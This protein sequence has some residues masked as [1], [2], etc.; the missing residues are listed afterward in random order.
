MKLS[1]FTFLRNADVDS[2]STCVV[3]SN[4]TNITIPHT[5]YEHKAVEFCP[6]KFSSFNAFFCKKKKKKKKKINFQISLTFTY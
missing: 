5:E 3:K 2:S 1:G 4:T 6:S